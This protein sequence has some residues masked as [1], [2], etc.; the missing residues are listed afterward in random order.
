MKAILIVVIAVSFLLLATQESD[1]K[2]AV[3]CV[4]LAVANG[5]LFA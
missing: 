1:V 5:V 4:L 2:L 3:G